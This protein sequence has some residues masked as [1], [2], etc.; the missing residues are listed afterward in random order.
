MG[1]K[2]PVPVTK[3]PTVDG[4]PVNEMPGMMTSPVNFNYTDIGTSVDCS[5]KSLD[6]GRF[7]LSISVDETSVV[8]GSAVQGFP[9]AGEPPVFRSFR[10]SN[11]IILRDGQSTQ[12]TAATDRV[13]GENIRVDVTINVMK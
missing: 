11:Q 5:A 9:K 2:I 13:T 8:S 10:V 7:E 6:D 3:Q 4:K 12:F 1:S